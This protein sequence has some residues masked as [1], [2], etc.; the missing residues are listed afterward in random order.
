VMRPYNV[1]IALVLGVTAESD[2]DAIE[3]ASALLQ[4]LWESKKGTPEAFSQGFHATQVTGYM[5]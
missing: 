3:K 2:A 4:E 1:D 5:R